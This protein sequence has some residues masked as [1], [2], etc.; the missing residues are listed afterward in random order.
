[1]I[2]YVKR[3]WQGKLPLWQAFWL[4]TIFIP[5]LLNVVLISLITTTSSMSLALAAIIFV[6]F[7]TIWS[8]IGCWRSAMD[9]G[10]SHSYPRALLAWAAALWILI[11]WVLFAFYF[12][13][14]SAVDAG[15][16]VQRLSA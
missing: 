8:L 5:K 13:P 1:M 4:N 10:T 6:F 7:E 2:E 11:S 14:D 15:F 12:M 16:Q 9:Y 3:H